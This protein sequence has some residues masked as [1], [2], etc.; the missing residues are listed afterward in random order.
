MWDENYSC[1]TSNDDKGKLLILTVGYD[2]D[3]IDVR[4]LDNIIT[5]LSG[6]PQGSS[7]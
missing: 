5:D 3:W 2:E 4:S 7:K 1:K 6:V